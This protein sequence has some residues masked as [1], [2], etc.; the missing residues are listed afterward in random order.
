[1]EKIKSASH[2]ATNKVIFDLIRPS[3]EVGSR[4]LDFGAGYGHMS[5]K[6]GTEAERR[7]ISPEEC[8]FACEIVPE[9]FQYD[10]VKCHKIKTDSIIPFDDNFFDLVYA[11][12]VLEHTPRPYDFLHE[13]IRTL[14]PN[15]TLIISVPNIMHALSR[16]SLFFN[17]FGEMFPPPSRH[18][19]NSGRICGHIMP[20]S[21]PYFHYGLAKEGFSEVSLTTDRRKKSCLF[22]AILLWPVFMFSR[23]AYERKL[24]KYDEEVWLEN[25]HLVLMLLMNLILY[26]KMYII[27][28]NYKI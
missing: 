21:Y 6:I 5:Q 12:E 1:M 20:L 25:K 26:L 24:R 19:R 2:P 3:I 17:G 10:K 28:A 22:W 9:E 14:K 27:I 23:K 18:C 7:G 11:I 4:I 16:F 13:A 8:I 15:G